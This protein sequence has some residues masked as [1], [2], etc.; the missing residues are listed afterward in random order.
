MLLGPGL[1][2]FNLVDP[3]PEAAAGDNRDREPFDAVLGLDT[4]AIVPMPL[5]VLSTV[6]N[7]VFV[8]PPDQIEK[9]FPGNIAGL[10]DADTHDGEVPI[11]QL[12]IA[13][14]TLTAALPWIALAICSSVTLLLLGWVIFRC[15]FG[16]DFTDEGFYLNWISN[17]WNYPASVTQFGF[18]YYPIYRLTGGDI[19]LLRQLNVL[20]VFALSF[21]LCV[22]LVRSLCWNWGELHW[23]QR[24]GFLGAAAVVASSALSFLD[25]WLPTPSYNSLTFQSLIVAAIGMLLANNKLSKAGIAGWLLIGIGGGFTFLAKPTSAFALACICGGYLIAAGKIAF[26]GLL[27]ALSS[28]LVLLVVSALAIDGSLPGFLKRLVDGV[29]LV[30]RLQ[31]DSGLSHLFRWDNYDLSHRQRTRFDYVLIVTYLSTTLGFLANRWAQLSATLTAALLAAMALAT[32]AGEFVPRIDYEPFQPVVFWAISFGIALSAVITRTHWLPSR[33]GL[34]LIVVLLMLPYVY[35]FGTN[36]NLWTTASRAALFWVMAGFVISIEL[37]AANG[38]WRPLLPAAAVALFVA[39]VIVYLAMEAPYRQTQ[40]LRFQADSVE[41]NRERASLI[42]TNEAASYIREITRLAEGSG[43]SPGDPVIDLTGVSPGSLYVL[44]ARPLG[45]AWLLAGY[46]GSNDFMTA[47]IDQETCGLIGAT[48]VLTEPNSRDAFSPVLLRRFGADLDQ[49]YVAVG[50]VYSTRTSTPK[51][52]E[53]RLYKPARD[54]VTARLA[55]ER[56]RQAN[57]PAQP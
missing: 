45:A 10:D 46:S 38:A 56:A 50:S 49:D 11:T 41:I 26:R 54:P 23:S 51:Q 33:N 44:G 47:A 7:D 48:W 4:V 24:A 6:V 3:L 17:P 29:N 21:T 16:F 55:C 43:F 31:P 40:P 20:T 53:H 15:R 39:T 5:N 52:F 35:A 13:E 18:V 57:H 37:A 34:A 19:A 42:L 36:N 1:S 12:K 2:N 9:T 32:I 27:I 22:V 28:A 25:L 8:A 30:D 14:R